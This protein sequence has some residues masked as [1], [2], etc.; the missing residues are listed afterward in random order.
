MLT[1]FI[2]HAGISPQTHC[3]IVR[4]SARA[5]QVVNNCNI[6][7]HS[8][9]THSILKATVSHSHWFAD[10]SQREVEKPISTVTKLRLLYTFFYTLFSLVVNIPDLNKL[11]WYFTNY[12][13][14]ITKVGLYRRICSKRDCITPTNDVSAPFADDYAIHITL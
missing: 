11:C 10:S 13:N 3:G 7:G 12:I 2:N 14:R 5:L 9:L 4:S 6:E 8:L 1:W